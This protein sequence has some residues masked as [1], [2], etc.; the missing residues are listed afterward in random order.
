MPRPSTMIDR[1]K[2]RAAIRQLGDEAVFSL[3]DDALDL[4]PAGKLR[5]VVK[6]YVDVRKLRP[7]GPKARVL[8]AVKAFEQASLTGAYCDSFNVNSRNFTQ[9]SKGT[10]TWIAECNR[11]LDHCVTQARTANPAQ[12][13]E[14][15][16]ILFGLLDRID[17]GEGDIVFFADE[18]G[19]WQVGVDWPRVLP[20]WFKV[21]SA[22]AEPE[23]YAARIVALVQH[24]CRYD[25]VK[26]LAA[27]RKGATP[28]QRQ[29]LA[30]AEAAAASPRSRP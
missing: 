11:L 24:H 30:R 17:E 23:E 3:L 8:A 18:A 6:R 27:A 2:L 21:L 9:L 19:S 26:L 28:A 25:S 1:D 5:R 10:R 14:A 7:D 22:T 16:D 15:F 13:R 12:V 20:P 29:A 4:V